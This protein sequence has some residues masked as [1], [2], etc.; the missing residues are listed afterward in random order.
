MPRRASTR[1]LYV[2]AILTALVSAVTGCS[3]PLTAEA[4]DE[5]KRSYPL[6]KGG[7]VEIGT[8]TAKSGSSLATPPPSR[9]SPRAAPAPAATRTR[10]TR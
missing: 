1:F 9:S 5:W 4:H 6:E 3:L 2:I 10:A 7:L 8:P